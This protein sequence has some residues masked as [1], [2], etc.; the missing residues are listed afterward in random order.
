MQSAG[1]GPKVPTQPT[2]GRHSR[3]VRS[4]TEGAAIIDWPPRGTE[5]WDRVFG[6]RA[7]TQ[8]HMTAPGRPLFEGG[9]DPLADINSDTE[10]DEHHYDEI[11]WPPAN[12]VQSAGAG[13]R[14]LVTVREPLRKL[15]K[16]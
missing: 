10:D 1:T 5:D 9:E 16:Q 6:P 11:A 15:T 4:E 14:K 8:C 7:H 13:P 2:M 12:S 3:D